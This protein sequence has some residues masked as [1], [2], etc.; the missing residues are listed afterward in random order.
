MILVFN[1]TDVKDASFAKEWMT[2]FEAF[3]EA[4]QRDESSDALGGVEGGGHGGSGYMGSLL[5]SMSLMLEEFYSH[6][7]MIAVSSRLGTGVDD[8]FAAVEEKRQEFMRDYYP[9]LQRRRATREQERN[10]TRD[11]EL[12]KMMQGM[13]VGQSGAGKTAD[14]DDQVDVASD[15]DDDD[16]DEDDEDD[17]DNDREGLQGRYQAALGDNDDSIM[18]DASFAKYL[19]KQRNEE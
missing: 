6:L 13:A 5:H 7:S 10:K 4:L 17:A 15:D 18:A 16:D 14:S 19:H 9:E 8:F 11:R 1:K 12:D 2:D 3:Q